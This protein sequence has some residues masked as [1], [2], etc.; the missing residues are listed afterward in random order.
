VGFESL[1]LMAKGEE[2]KKAP[3]FDKHQSIKYF[4]V[5]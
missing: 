5:P 1:E 2:R 3:T 4:K